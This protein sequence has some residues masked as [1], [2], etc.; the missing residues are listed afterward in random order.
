MGST[1][2]AAGVSLSGSPIMGEAQMFIPSQ[3]SGPDCETVAGAGRPCVAAELTG[4]PAATTGV[5]LSP[6]ENDLLSKIR[7]QRNGAWLGPI[8]GARLRAAVRLAELGLIEYELLPGG[9]AMG[10]WFRARSPVAVDTTTPPG[11]ADPAAHSRQW[12]PFVEARQFVWGLR[13]RNVYEWM[14]YCQSKLDRPGLPPIPPDL[15][16][17]PQ[18]RTVYPGQWRGWRNWLGPRRRS[19][20]EAREFVHKLGFGSYADWTAYCRG[21]MPHLP[22]LPSDIPHS[23]DGCKEY[24]THWRGVADW[25]GVTRKVYRTYEEARAWVHQLHLPNRAAWVCYIK[26]EMPDLPLLPDDISSCPRSYYDAR[27]WLNWADF[28][29]SI[30]CRVRGQIMPYEKARAFAHSLYLGSFSEWTDY[31]NGKYPDLPARPSTLPRSPQIV[32]VKHG[33]WKGVQ[34][35]LGYSELIPRGERTSRRPRKLLPID[36]AEAFVHTLLLTSSTE[37]FAYRHG[38]IPRLG[39]CPK[40]LPWNP[41]T[42]MGKEWR[43]WAHWL[44]PS[45]KPR[46]GSGRC[47]LSFEDARKEVGLL[48]LRTCLEWKRS[49]RGELG[50]PKIPRHIP[51][52]PS[53][54]YSADWKGWPYWLGT[55]PARVARSSSPKTSDASNA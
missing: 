36:R 35:F 10:N 38:S 21:E 32:Y 18:G 47:S 11:V 16:L 30:T 55:G 37:W 6:T 7:S 12:R 53:V 27:G 1:Y 22:A 48:G 14:M 44:G 46:S 45:Y 19:F 3:P 25:L 54:T 42:A 9:R 34:D 15:P 49:L 40:F 26:G 52:Y 50:L 23:P 5:R 20:G 39:P 43:G 41:K 17:H 31:A 8:K 2:S 33:G 4:T 13:L 24:R 28:L 51:R 29:G